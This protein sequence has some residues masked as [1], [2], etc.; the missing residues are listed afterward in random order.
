MAVTLRDRRTAYD[1]IASGSATGTE[2][3]IAGAAGPSQTWGQGEN[4]SNAT[5]YGKENV[6]KVATA[7]MTGER[8]AV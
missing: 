4:I 2:R 7:L 6:V 5:D 8:V 1:N 3:T